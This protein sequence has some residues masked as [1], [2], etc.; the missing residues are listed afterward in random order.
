MKLYLLKSKFVLELGPKGL[1]SNFIEVHPMKSGLHLKHIVSEL[2]STPEFGLPTIFDGFLPRQLGSDF[3]NRVRDNGHCFIF[4][5]ANF[6][7]SVIDVDNNNKD[8]LAIKREMKLRKL[9]N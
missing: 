1:L 8:L 3:I 5:K 9:I 7:W 2:E 4:R 6:G